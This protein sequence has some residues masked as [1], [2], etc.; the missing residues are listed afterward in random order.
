MP[1]RCWW[2][3]SAGTIASQELVVESSASDAATV[4]AEPPPPLITDEQDVVVAKNWVLSC[5]ASA[6]PVTPSCV[7]EVGRVVA[8]VMQSRGA[9]SLPFVLSVVSRLQAFAAKDERAADL[10]VAWAHLSLV[11]LVNCGTVLAMPQLARYA[12]GLLRQRRNRN[13]LARQFSSRLADGDVGELQ[14]VSGSKVPEELLRSQS[15]H[16]LPVTL[17]IS[18]EAV[19]EAITEEASAEVY[20]VF[21]AEAAAELK[22]AITG[23]LLN[24]DAD[25]VGSSSLT[26]RA[27][28][29]AQAKRHFS[30]EALRPSHS[31]EAATITVVVVDGGA[32]EATAVAGDAAAAAAPSGGQELFTGRARDCIADLLARHG[33]GATTQLVQP[34]ARAALLAPTLD[35]R[36][37][38][39]YARKATSDAAGAG[40][41]TSGAADSRKLSTAAAALPE[42]PVSHNVLSDPVKRDHGHPYA[43]RG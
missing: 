25:E 31:D 33:V 7:I 23:A 14:L 5:I 18:F 2:A 8:A 32:A 42:L 12:M 26:P 11:V 28:T 41:A 20:A 17:L 30:L 24:P 37:K 39:R 3:S 27:P 38:V 34:H 22:V 4:M 40:A 6:E 13:E 36:E 29:R 1:P 10:H 16:H 19:A 35:K 43:S 21:G 9:S 15:A